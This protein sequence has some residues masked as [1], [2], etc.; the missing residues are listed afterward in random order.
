MTKSEFTDQIQYWWSKYCNCEFRFERE[1]Y[2]KVYTSMKEIYD[3]WVKENRFV[4]ERDCK[5]K[6]S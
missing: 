3:L 6:V 5:T 4:E 2:L 1:L